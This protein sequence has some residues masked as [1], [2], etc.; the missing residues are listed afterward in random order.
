MWTEDEEKRKNKTGIKKSRKKRE[1]E[2]KVTKSGKKKE[3]R[4]GVDKNI[5]V[6]AVIRR[7]KIQWKTKEERAEWNQGEREGGSNAE[8]V[9]RKDKWNAAKKHVTWK[10]KIVKGWKKRKERM[11]ENEWEK[12]EN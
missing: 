5:S 10:E 7:R 3:K 8:T 12:K 11:T 1:R 2:E 4:L 9:K 6:E